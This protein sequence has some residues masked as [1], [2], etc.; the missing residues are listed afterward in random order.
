MKI[1]KYKKPMWLILLHQKALN[2]LITASILAKNRY[3]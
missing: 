2:R 3:P 1:E